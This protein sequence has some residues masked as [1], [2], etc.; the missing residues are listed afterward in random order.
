[1]PFKPLFQ[2]RAQLALAALAF[3]VCVACGGNPE[4][5]VPDHGIDGRGGD[6][7]QVDGTGANGSS[8]HVGGQASDVGDG[9]GSSCDTSDPDCQTRCAAD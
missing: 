4:V 7:G 2:A 3:T 6:P 1:M 8:I 5:V 9:G